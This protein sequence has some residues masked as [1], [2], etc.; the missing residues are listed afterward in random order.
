M[1]KSS[2]QLDLWLQLWHGKRVQS[3]KD[4][5]EPG[6]LE[7][8][9]SQHTAQWHVGRVC[10]VEMLLQSRLAHRG[11]CS[12]CLMSQREVRSAVFRKPHSRQGQRAGPVLKRL[13]GSE[14]LVRGC[15]VRICL[16][17]TK[18]KGDF[19]CSNMADSFPPLLRFVWM[20]VRV[21]WIFSPHFPIC[22]WP[23]FNVVM[24]F[25]HCFRSC[26]TERRFLGYIRYDFI[27]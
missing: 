18:Q 26:F 27:S 13:V 22:M 5:S 6:G 12:L 21:G 25:Q 1:V 14:D 2:H 17:A 16:K 10:S 23:C 9:L 19:S 3:D 11:C 24:R 15:V 4:L 20:C 7:G 8:F